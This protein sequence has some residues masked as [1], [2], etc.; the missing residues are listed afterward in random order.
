MRPGQYL[1]DV[2]IGN[3]FWRMLGLLFAGVALT[4]ISTAIVFDRFSGKAPETGTVVAGYVGLVFFGLG[5]CVAGWNLLSPKT[6]VLFITRDGIR[7]TRSSWKFL[8]WQSV[9]AISTWQ[10]RRE[11][12]LVLKLSPAAMSQSATTTTGRTLIALNKMLGLEGIPIST[13]TLAVNADELLRTCNAYL[14]AARARKT[15]P[16][17]FSSPQAGVDLVEHG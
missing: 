9:E 8:P 10:V 13:G 2:E 12:F 14:A 7:D 3:S 4:L 11:Q 16:V 5:A 15:R 6:P 1:P 17:V